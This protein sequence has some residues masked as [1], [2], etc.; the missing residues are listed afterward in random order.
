MKIDKTKLQLVKETLEDTKG[1]T[2]SGT[3]ACRLW[4]ELKGLIGYVE[5]E[6]ELFRIHQ[7][8]PGAP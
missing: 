1:V 4:H 3:V 7:N 6:M 5:R 2:G 8:P